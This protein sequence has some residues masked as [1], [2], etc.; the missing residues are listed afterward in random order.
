MAVEE[1]K[2]TLVLGHRN[3]DTDSICSAIC[4]AG[5]KH[6]LTGENYEPCRAGNVN[7]E[8][9][10]VLD[11]FKLKAP[12]LVE[13]VK[14][15]VK[16]IEIRKTKGVSR[17]IS[18]KNAWGL[19]Q[20]NNVVTLPC[21]TEEGL[22]EGVITIGDITKSYM[23][24]YDS[25]IISKACTKYANILDT[26]EGSMVVGDSEAYFDRGKVL[27]AAANPDL[28]E[29][30]IEKHDLVILGNRYESQLCAIE[31]EAGCIIVCE[32]AGV[33]LTIRKLA[34]ERG[35]AVITTPYDTYTTARLINQSMPIS[36]FMTKENIIEFSEEDYLDDIREI[37]A[38]KRHRDFPIL[39]SDG[40]YIGMISRRN[41]L[42]AKGKSIILVDHNE[43]SQAVEGMESADIREIID[44]HRLGT[45]ETMS[46]V[47]FRNQPL[48]CTATIIYQMYQENHIEIDKTTA[49]LLCSA[50]ISDT[51]LFRSPT[52]TP[53]DKAA[54]L[55]LAQI[56][57]LDI[58]KYA[59][60]MFS[61]G[62]NLKGKSDGDIFYQD[63]KRFTVGNSVFGIGQ[64]TSL[65]AVELK[66][67]RTRMS[68]YTEKEREQ[69][70]I[71]MMF[72]MLT[73]IL[74]EST[75]LICTG[76]GAEQLIAN[77]FHVKDEDMENVSG[78]TGIVKLPGVV[79]RKK[80]LAPQIMMA[81]Q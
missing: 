41:L 21:V 62:S 28:M 29:N 65:N 38:S 51:L 64:I 10:Y 30:Y 7:P 71:D 17:G 36:Y 68:A 55:A 12:R 54:G 22:L 60:D 9:Q 3:P 67:L 2:K 80:Q 45:V 74:T 81:L 70:E 15:Q 37:M 11:Y 73:N 26:L 33:S 16:D 40:K 61:A 32:G 59:I 50:I 49:G 76:Q 27:I 66:D 57:G 19:M 25:S 46:P 8:T 75:D 5:F 69:H 58:E 72:F 48:G 63:F 35:C 56:A 14:T 34:Q 18:L 43:K 53:I 47:F 6:Q 42:G 77:A 31:M 24:L 78:Q 52:C 23:N 39:D 79:S 1:L 13:N 44:H 4:Y 20:E